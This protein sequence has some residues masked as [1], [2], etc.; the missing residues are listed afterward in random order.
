MMGFKYLMYDGF[1]SFVEVKGFYLWWEKDFYDRLVD[2]TRV[3]FFGRILRE[4]DVLGVQ[5]P[6]I[7]LI[8]KRNI[9]ICTY[10]IAFTCCLIK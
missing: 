6:S 1:T 7:L 8:T 5:N 9:T 3:I 2:S 10:L 4:T